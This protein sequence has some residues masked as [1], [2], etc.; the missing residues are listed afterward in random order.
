MSFITLRATQEEKELIQQTAQLE[1]KSVSEYI[2]AVVLEK[3]END[4]D[5]KVGINALHEYEKDPETFSLS[6]IKEKYDL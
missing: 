3:I 4:Y 5:L 2:K 6:E 1:G